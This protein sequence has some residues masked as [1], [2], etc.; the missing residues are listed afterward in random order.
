MVKRKS[1]ESES[2]PTTKS[3]Q[4]RSKPT[5]QPPADS[6]EISQSMPVQKRA[7][8]PRSKSKVPRRTASD[9]VGKGLAG[10]KGGKRD[11]KSKND[12]GTSHVTLLPGRRMT[13]GK[14]HQT[15]SALLEPFYYGKGLNDPI[16]TAR[17]SL[18]SPCSV[19]FASYHLVGQMEPRTCLSQSQRSCQTAY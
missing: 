3:S 4:A 14:D 19:E 16:N 1:G 8:A 15:F 2:V 5:D 12:V 6:L 7:S 13:D 18:N 9:Q 11:E 10:E 17:V